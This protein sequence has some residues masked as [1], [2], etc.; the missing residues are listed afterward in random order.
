MTSLRITID[1]LIRT[2][3]QTKKHIPVVGLR[4][5]KWLCL[6]V[7]ISELTIWRAI[8]NTLT[9]HTKRDLPF[10][11]ADVPQDIHELVEQCMQDWRSPRIP[12][13][14]QTR[15]IKL[16][17][18]KP[19]SINVFWVF[20]CLARPN[21]Y[22]EIGRLLETNT[23]EHVHFRVKVVIPLRLLSDDVKRALPLEGTKIVGDVLR[24]LYITAYLACDGDYVECFAMKVGKLAHVLYDP[25][26]QYK[27]CGPSNM[28]CLELCKEKFSDY[29]AVLRAS[30]KIFPKKYLIE[31]VPFAGDVEKWLNAKHKDVV[32]KHIV[33]CE[34]WQLPPIHD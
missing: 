29:A 9:Y 19:Q 22:S 18:V 3:E 33:E 27:G 10:L 23:M 13:M 11:V 1:A 31:W 34:H 7:V 24:V 25:I 26:E 4:S 8:H 21:Q 32:E 30:A 16:L 12:K 15:W 28:Y 14:L 2:A 5:L 6:R 20:R 17:R